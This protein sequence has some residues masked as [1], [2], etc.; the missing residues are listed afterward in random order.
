MVTWQRQPW[1]VAVASALA[2]VA[3]DL[4]TKYLAVRD[5]M[6]FGDGLI[7]NDDLPS[8]AAR[9]ATVLGTMLVTIV[10]A[11]IAERTGVGAVPF[12]WLA[13]GL[14]VGGVLGNW[15]AGGLWSHGVPDF[16]DGGERMWNLA[17]FTIGLGMLLFLASSVG[18]AVRT[19][20]RSTHAG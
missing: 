12:I 6:L 18:Y 7:Y 16:I 14:L 1:L 19:Y 9:V 5:P 15:I 17:D 10:I 20:A 2:V 3:V 13:C 4:V 8:H 11:R